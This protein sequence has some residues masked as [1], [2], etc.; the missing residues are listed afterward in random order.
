MF[1]MGPREYWMKLR[2]REACHLLRLGTQEISDV[3]I[4]LGFC[5]QS[6]FTV[7]FRRNVGVTPAHYAKQHHASDKHA[8]RTG[9]SKGS[10]FFDSHT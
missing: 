3:A 2:I 10:G 5:D 7:H 6:T 1:G 8:H 9:R 4:E